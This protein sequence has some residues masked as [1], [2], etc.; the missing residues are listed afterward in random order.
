MTQFDKKRI[1]SQ[2]KILRRSNKEP[3]V[4]GARN[5]RAILP[6]YPIETPFTN[7]EEIYDYLSGD[8]IVCLRC[9]K[10]YKA[11][12]IH[13]KVHGWD[14][15]RYKEYYGLPWRT[16]LSCDSTRALNKKRGKVK[17][18]KEKRL[19]IGI[20]QYTE[21]EKKQ[22]RAKAHKAPH[23]KRAAYRKVLDTTKVNS[24][25]VNA[26]DLRKWKD[27]HYWAIL[28]RMRVQDRPPSS[29][30]LD[31]DMPG[32][33]QMHDFKRANP[34]YAEALERVWE[35]LSFP[36]QSKAEHLGKRFK[37]VATQ[38]RGE[39]FSAREIAIKLG[40]HKQT[41][42]VLLSGVP[43]KPRTHCPHGHLYPTEGPKVCKRCNTLNARKHRG[44]LG[45]TAKD[46]VEVP[47]MCCG[48]PVKRKRFKSK[49]KAKCRECHLEY[50]K[51]YDI[52][53]RGMKRTPR[54]F[55]QPRT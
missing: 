40:V 14:A 36:V 19:G 21:E 51:Q 11:L 24:Y 10:P 28:E 2:D 47:C 30:C 4:R 55:K 45:D 25:V 54:N 43:T 20:H 29:V 34:S 13:I 31:D 22:I 49:M 39:G 48:K 38:L 23:R 5:R 8:R 44:Y 46:I 7:P 1:T 9:G 41:I 15:A 37:F 27:G 50:Q 16:G 6:G 42:L 33:T 12:H 18:A 35:S 53:V 17:A 3:A 32:L 26:D 52:K